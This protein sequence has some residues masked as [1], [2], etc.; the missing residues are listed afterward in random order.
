MYRCAVLFVFLL[1]AACGS[2]S[3]GERPGS[4]A[5]GLTTQAGGS[6][7]RLVHARFALEGPVSR[8]LLA[9]GEETLSVELAPGEYTL[10]LLAGWGLQRFDPADA[11]V[12]TTEAAADLG[13]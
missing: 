6:S 13:A 12:A 2:A 7:Y 8:A 3:D 9:D 5:V 11:V 10:T 1:L 4:L